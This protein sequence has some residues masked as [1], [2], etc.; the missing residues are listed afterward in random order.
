MLLASAH[1]PQLH[2]AAGA[3]GHQCRCEAIDTVDLDPIQRDDYVA[4][5]KT[6]CCGRRSF[7]WADDLRAPRLSPAEPLS[8]LFGDC[9]LVD[10]E[11]ARAPLLCPAPL[12]QEK[13]QYKH[14]KIKCTH[15]P[16]LPPL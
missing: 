7:E 14:Q 4:R 12:C 5:L 9:L 11:P 10:P 13:N 16:Q 8:L 15:A 1:E 2:P 3:L 6:R